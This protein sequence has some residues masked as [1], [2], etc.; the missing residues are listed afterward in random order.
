MVEELEAATIGSRAE[1]LL[2]LFIEIWEHEVIPTEWKHRVIIHIY[3]KKVNLN[4][5]NHRSISLSCH[6]SKSFSSSVFLQR[7]KGRTERKS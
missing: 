1:A 4:C 5:S 6:S 7:I 3:K 2:R